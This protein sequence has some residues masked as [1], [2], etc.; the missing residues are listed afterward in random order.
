MTGF[1]SYELGVVGTKDPK[2]AVMKYAIKRLLHAEIVDGAEWLIT[3]GQLG[4]EQWSIEAAHEMIDDGERIKT[5]LMTPY[6]GFGSQWNEANQ[7]KLTQLK[8]VVDFSA[9]VTQG[10]YSGPSQLRTYQSFMLAHT[11]GAIIFFDQDAPE[12]KASYD[13]EVA[14]K[15]AET[16]DYPIKLIDFDRL[17][18]FANEYQESLWDS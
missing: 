3:G 14:Q 7:Q 8:G 9:P 17:Q 1:R 4:I 2:L 18:D 5:A 13:Y 11:D 16:H 6:S 10:D 12:S 15:F